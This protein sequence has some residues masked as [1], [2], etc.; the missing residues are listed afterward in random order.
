VSLF[1]KMLL[2]VAFVVACVLG[3]DLF[4]PDAADVTHPRIRFDPKTGQF[5]F[6]P[7]QFQVHITYASM[8]GP[9]EPVMRIRDLC[10]SRFEEEYS[11]RLAKQ[12][13]VVIPDKDKA[14]FVNRTLRQ[15]DRLL[16]D[17]REKLK[18]ITDEKDEGKRQQFVNALESWLAEREILAMPPDPKA[19]PEEKRKSLAA[20]V[21]GLEALVEDAEASWKKAPLATPWSAKDSVVAK[22]VDVRPWLARVDRRWQG[23]WVLTANRPRFLTGRDVP[24]VING[25]KMELLALVE[26]DYAVPLNR[27]LELTK[28]EQ[29]NPSPADLTKAPLDQPDTYGDPRRSWGDAF[30]APMLEEG[31]YTFLKDRT[32]TDL[33]YMAPCR[34]TTFCIFYN[35]VLFKKAGVKPPKT[36]PELLEVCRK[37]REAGITPLTADAEVY[38]DNWESWLVFRALGP[39]AW[40]KTITGKSR[41]DGDGKS[42][43]KW[44]APEYRRVFEA[45]RD[46]RAPG[47]FEDS[48]RGSKWP[49]AQR[50]F[51]RGDAAMLI[52]GTWLYQELGGYKDL[53]SEDVFKLNCFGFP[54][55]PAA[56]NLTPAQQAAHDV[57]QKAFWAG[58]SGLMVC[59]QGKATPHAIE[60]VKY[61]S[62]HDHPYLVHWN[63]L[64]SCMK[65]ADFPPTLKAIE[66]DFRNTP[67]VYSRTPNVY[68]RRYGSVILTPMYQDFFLKT[69]GESDYLGVDEFLTKLEEKTEAYIAAGGEE[70]L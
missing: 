61:L 38:C 40:E 9:G 5:T 51:A 4:Q 43:L 33:V 47:N 60:L 10:I 1:Y 3:Y 15:I 36:W 49:A 24:D 14:A 64:I 11:D 35:E 28:E 56:G 50:G 2:A 37:L 44:T 27:P 8:F 68:A 26:D 6:R 67:A 22:R 46:L 18:R 20:L 69:K 52:C 57:R 17:I 48:F 62:A 39:D 34:C 70:G 42:R 59:R 16:P 23:R 30:I 65:D 66:R 7:P 31:K 58:A 32:R 29:D 54:T 41:K 21:A 53:A 25:S 45:I 13:N 63:G 55:W 19:G 12:R